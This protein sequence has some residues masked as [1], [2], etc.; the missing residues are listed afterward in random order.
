MTICKETVTKLLKV[1]D[2]K[3]PGALIVG[4]MVICNKA[5]DKASLRAMVFLNINQKEGLGFQRY[6]DSVAKVVTAPV[7][8]S[9]R[10]I[11]KA[12]FLPSGN[13]SG[14]SSR[15]HSTKHK[16]NIN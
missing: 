16:K 3:I 11:S 10:K 5:V 14:S 4:N 12:I 9:P 7:S 8:L 6:A 2:L 15:P 13:K 1:S